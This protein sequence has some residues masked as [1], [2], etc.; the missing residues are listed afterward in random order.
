MSNA[1]ST[2]SRAAWI[3]EIA[4]IAALYVVGAHLRLF[5]PFTEV[6]ASWVWIPSGI[7]LA[8][9]LLRG[10]D[11][12]P[13]VA[14]G[15]LVSAALTRLAL[16]VGAAGG[17]C[18]RDRRSA[19][20]RRRCCAGAAPSTARC[21]TSA[22]CCGSW[23]ASPLSA[24][25]TA[26]VG[27][28]NLIALSPGGGGGFGETWL[29][30]W[31]GDAMA[32]LTVT[33]T[34]LVWA[35]SRVRFPGRWRRAEFAALLASAFIVGTLVFGQQTWPV[36]VVLPV[37]YTSFPLMVWSAFRF[38]QPGVTAVTAI[39]ATLAL[40]G[41]GRGFGP[42]AQAL[43]ADRGGAGGRVHER[44]GR[45][46]ADAGRAGAGTHAGAERAARQRG[47][48]P[49]LHAALAGHRVHEE[50]RR[51]LRVRQPRV[52]GPVRPSRRHAAR[53]DRLRPV[54]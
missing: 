12:W 40:V 36:H 45:H 52:G 41:S 46:R 25:V 44:G 23:P 54:A 29:T 18:L 34:L 30:F 50:Q 43:D 20:G 3:A 4:L 11:R 26:I 28:W 51:P 8:A 31:V 19:A 13:G 39:I 38:G 47:A 10:T 1:S 42:F 24:A 2:G 37:A 5:F 27:A 35:G 48:I 53:P 21:R 49:R 16:A 9:L 14:L 32:M 6:G 33:P 15:A 7:S 17:R 22:P